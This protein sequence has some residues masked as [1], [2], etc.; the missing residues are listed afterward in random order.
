MEISMEKRI[1]IVVATEH[2]HAAFW[3]HELKQIE[4]AM[5][6]GSVVM[7]EPNGEAYRSLKSAWT[8]SRVVRAIEE[9]VGVCV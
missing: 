8:T 9:A 1:L 7:L 4:D 6:G 2:G 5:T 3:L